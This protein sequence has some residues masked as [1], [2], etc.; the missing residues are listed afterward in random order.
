[1]PHPG[2]PGVRQAHDAVV[3]NVTETARSGQALFPA[4]TALVSSYGLFAKPST[5]NDHRGTF[6]DRNI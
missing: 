4:I 6:S 3:G 2:N 5:I 1:V